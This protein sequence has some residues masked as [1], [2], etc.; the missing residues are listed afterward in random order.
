MLME[1]VGNTTQR[2]MFHRPGEKEIEI[3]IH[4]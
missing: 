1:F 4:P 3:K 2:G